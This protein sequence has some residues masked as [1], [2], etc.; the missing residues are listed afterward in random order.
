MAPLL[1]S[2][3]RCHRAR[4]PRPRK[5]LHFGPGRSR[6]CGAPAASAGGLSRFERQALATTGA[7]H[8]TKLRPSR[9]RCLWLRWLR[10]RAPAEAAGAPQEPPALTALGENHSR[11]A[12]KLTIRSTGPSCRGR[13]LL[14]TAS[15]SL[16]EIGLPSSAGWR[17]LA[18]LDRPREPRAGPA[19]RLASSPPALANH[20][21]F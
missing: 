18:P 17:S 1:W 10:A 8:P 11:H 4:P 3:A 12:K 19:R 2:G 7:W 6:S 20:P 16:N 5:R 13:E 21:R 14:E 9:P 15:A